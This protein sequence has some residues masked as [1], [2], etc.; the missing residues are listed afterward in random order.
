VAVGSQHP[1]RLRKS[2]FLSTSWEVLNDVEHGNHVEGSRLEGQIAGVSSCTRTRRVVDV[3]SD[4]EGSSG[5]LEKPAALAAHIEQA[6]RVQA[7][8]D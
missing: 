7:V 5:V 6:L 8:D 1:R 2:N 4:L 3:D